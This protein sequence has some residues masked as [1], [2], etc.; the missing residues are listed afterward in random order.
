MKCGAVMTSATIAQI[1]SN[2]IIQLFLAAGTSSTRITAGLVRFI[3]VYRS[4]DGCNFV[5]SIFQ[6]GE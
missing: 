2:N 1:I 4:L 3:S 6:K 5:E